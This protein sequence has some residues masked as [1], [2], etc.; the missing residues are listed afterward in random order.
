MMV[1]LVVATSPLVPPLLV[2]AGGVLSAFAAPASYALRYGIAPDGR[3]ATFSGITGAAES[4]GKAAGPTFADA[5]MGVWRSTRRSSL[6]A[7]RG[8]SRF[9]RWWS[10]CHEWW[11]GSDSRPGRDGPVAAGVRRTAYT[12]TGGRTPAGAGG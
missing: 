8:W 2:F 7:S 11:T 3:E 9:R 5:V 4:V 12:W 10:S 1:G 6:P